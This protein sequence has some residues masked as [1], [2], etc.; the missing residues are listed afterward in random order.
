MS[1]GYASLSGGVVVLISLL[2]ARHFNA[3][4]GDYSVFYSV[5]WFLAAMC[6]AA[7]FARYSSRGI[8]CRLATVLL[9]T[10]IASYAAFLSLHLFRAMNGASASN[11]F[12]IDSLLVGIVMPF[13]LLFGWLHFL[14]LAMIVVLFSLKKLN[15]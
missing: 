9:S 2:K 13:G 11:P 3:V 8:V 12:T 7:W 6:S 15:R 14:L 4:L 1:V 10:V 5:A